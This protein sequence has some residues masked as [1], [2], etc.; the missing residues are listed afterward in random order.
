MTLIRRHVLWRLIWVC[1][2]CL[3][4]IK[5]TLGLYG[6]NYG[7]FSAP[8]CEKPVDPPNG[9]HYM[10]FNDMVATLVCDEGFRRVGSRVRYCN[11]FRWTG[12]VAKCRGEVIVK[13]RIVITI[14]LIL[15]IYKIVCLQQYSVFKSLLHVTS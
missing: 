3:C 6:L 8:G 11:G 12:T 14:Q 4:H 9:K 1:T 10:D 15:F 5:R 13:M 7:L 2:V